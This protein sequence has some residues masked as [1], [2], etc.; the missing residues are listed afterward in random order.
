MN[1]IIYFILTVIQIVSHG[2]KAYSDLEQEGYVH[3]F[4]NQS[5]VFVNN[6][7]RTVH[8]QNRLKGTVKRKGKPGRHNK[9]YLSEYI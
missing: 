4:N 8:T 9:T 2:W 3:D 7:D 1:L 5:V 6:E